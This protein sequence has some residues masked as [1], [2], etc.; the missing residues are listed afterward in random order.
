SEQ[1]SLETQTVETGKKVI[2]AG[3]VEKPG[4][5]EIEDGMTL[6]DVIT[7]DFL[8]Q[9]IWNILLIFLFFR[10]TKEISLFCLRKIVSFL[11]PN[12]TL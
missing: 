7:E 10:N 3:R 8:P 9:S 11:F 5:V 4:V 6:Q 1:L 12:S 2:V